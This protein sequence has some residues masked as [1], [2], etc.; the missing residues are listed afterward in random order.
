[1]TT[2]RT[3]GGTIAKITRENIDRWI[4]ENLFQAI[5][6]AVA[7]I[8]Q[9]YNLVYAN[10]AFTRMFGAWRNK[11]CYTVY[12]SRES[13]CPDCKGKDAFFDGFARVNEE[14]GYNKNGRITHYIKHTVPIVNDDGDVPFLLEMVT[15]ITETVHIRREHQLLFDQ[16]PCNILVIDRDYRIVRTNRRCREM[17]GDIEGKFCYKA[18]RGEGQICDR[19]LA[20][21]TFQDGRLHSGHSAVRGKDGKEVHMHVTYV[22]LSLEDGKMDL[23]MEMAVDV[24]QLMDLQTQ[25]KIALT[26][27]ETMIA[28]SLDGIITIDDKHDITIFNPAA[29]ALFNVQGR[30]RVEKAELEA[31]MPE[32]FLSRVETADT[33]VYLPDTAVRTLDGG[34]CPVR[35]AGIRL[36]VDERFLGMAFWVQDMRKYKQLEKEKLEAERLAAV[37]QTVAGLAHGI[38]NLI[39]G[40]EGGLYMLNSGMKKGNVDRIG[41]GMEMLGRNIERVAAFVKEFL[42]FS[43]GRTIQAAPC[44]PRAIAEEVVAMYSPRARELGIELVHEAGE[45]IPQAPLDGAG[46][47]ECLTNLVGNAMDA[48]VMSE[49]RQ[50]CHV[51]VS[52]LERDGA[53]VYQVVD[54][55]CGMDYQVKQKVFTTFFT[56][57]GLGGTGLGLLTTKKIVQEHG[58][59]VEMESDKGKG[60]TFRIVLPRSRLPQAAGAQDAPEP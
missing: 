28:E 25:L 39:T 56:T 23:V 31:M 49:D 44:D 32:G 11:K 42:S 10:N 9:E 40:L 52:T 6:M 30:R 21:E 20:R 59:H 38:K 51:R 46:I 8:D 53:L 54:D 33:H 57:K 17:F 34:S 22:P 24:T 58:G 41:Q 45:A 48:C 47:H 29:R 16:V 36:L 43:K 60:S 18:F 26:V 50:N 5:P 12:K 7:V 2:G 3:G 55:G 19:C 35:L 1:M 13:V 4:Q 27:M 14:V 15:D 37:G